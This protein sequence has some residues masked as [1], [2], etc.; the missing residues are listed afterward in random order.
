MAKEWDLKKRT[1]QFG[2]DVT[3]FCSKYPSTFEGR[4][5][6]QQLFRAATGTAAA[7][8]AVC[9][10]KSDPDLTSKFGTAI[11][12][13]DESGFWLDFSA[14]AQLIRPGDERALAQEAD[15]L[16]RI[17]MQGRKTARAKAGYAIAK[18]AG[19]VILSLLVL[20]SFFFLLAFS[21]VLPSSFILRPCLSQSR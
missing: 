14:A 18:G 10:G 20:S 15:E 9:R 3:K 17:F 12:E 16:V 2:L 6:R 5:V 4:H 21:F 11:E 19:I 7:Y 13:A 8:R 1:M